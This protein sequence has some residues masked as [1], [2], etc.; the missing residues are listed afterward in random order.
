MTLP[1]IKMLFFWSKHSFWRTPSLARKLIFYTVFTSGLLTT[2]STTISTYRDY[3]SEIDALN[4]IPKEVK[5]SLLEPIS[6]A[7]WDYNDNLIQLQLE[8]ILNKRDVFAVEIKIDN[9]TKYKKTKT[10]DIDQ[11]FVH[12]YDIP[13]NHETTII[14][15]LIITASEQEA[16]YRIINKTIIFFISQFFKTFIVTLMMYLVFHRFVTTHLTKIVEFLRHYDDSHKQFRPLALDRTNH[17]RDELYYLVNSINAFLKK[18]FAF[19]RQQETMIATQNQTIKEQADKIINTAKLAS[20]GE[21]AGNIAHE[22]NNPLTIVQAYVEALSDYLPTE[23]TQRKEMEDIVDR[24]NRT[25]VRMTTIIKGMLFFSRESSG[26]EGETTTLAEIVSLTF[27]LCEDKFKQRSI[28][29]HSQFDGTLQF[30]C[31]KAQI[32][33]VLLNLLSNAADAL[34][35]NAE[36]N[37]HITIKSQQNATTSMIFVSDNGPG[38]PEAI[39]SK[40]M[41]PLFTT[42]PIGKGTGLGLSISNT[43]VQSHGGSLTLLASEEPGAHFMLSLPTQ[44]TALA[45]A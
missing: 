10:N 39:R 27:E 22:I 31:R 4:N 5:L 3:K 33:Q 34:M 2:I 42:K 23:E 25:V 37:R 21:M 35:S 40:I 8:G 45:T 17:E 41:D 26:I 43:I 30:Q 1:V 11:R 6:S 29:L 28:V 38:V 18:I 14:G 32:C 44:A 12:Q 20:I 36:N 15:V 7:L 13:L 9:K 19:Q 24:I 16:I